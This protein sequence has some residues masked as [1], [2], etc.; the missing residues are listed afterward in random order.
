MDI[1]TKEKAKEV[2]GKFL[3]LALKNFDWIP[4]KHFGLNMDAISELTASIQE[5]AKQSAMLYCDGMQEER[6]RGV[7]IAYAF[8]KKRL[9]SFEAKTRAGGAVAE[10]AFAEE[11]AAEECRYIGNAISGHNA[12]SAV[13]DEDDYWIRIKKEIENL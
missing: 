10:I 8:R 1:N 9:E 12:L 7:D 3:S 5:Q 13:L 11:K 2:F 6:R 4:K